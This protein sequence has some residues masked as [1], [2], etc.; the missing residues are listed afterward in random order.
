MNRGQMKFGALIVVKAMYTGG[1]AV[2]STDDRLM[3]TH[4]KAL[5]HPALAHPLVEI[6]GIGKNMRRT[7]ARITAFG[8]ACLARKANRIEANGIDDQ[9]AG[10][11]LSSKANRLWLR[12]V[13]KLV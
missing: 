9:I 8:K 5:G 6:F 11:H 13:E 2:D 10:V 4:L 12:D 3:F 1:L 7:E